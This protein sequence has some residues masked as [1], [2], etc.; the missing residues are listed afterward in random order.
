MGGLLNL[1]SRSGR[2]RKPRSRPTKS[3][4]APLSR[5]AAVVWNR[6]H[7][8][9]RL[10]VDAGGLERADRLLAYGARTAHQHVDRANAEVAGLVPGALR[11][12]LRGERCALARA[13]EP[14]ASGRGPGDHV[15]VRIADRDDGV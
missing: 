14:G 6:C 11:R 15:A 3:N 1:W 2:R 8:P 12:H 5:A 13:L 7:V 10:D 9:D 4:A